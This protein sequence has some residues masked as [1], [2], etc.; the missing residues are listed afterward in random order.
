[1]RILVC[2]GR[3]YGNWAQLCKT[4]K[5]LHEVRPITSIIH[6]DAFGADAMGATWGHLNGIFVKPFPIER[7]DWKKYDKAAG[8]MRNQQMLDEGKPDLVVAFP[9]NNGTADMVRRARAVGVEVLEV[10]G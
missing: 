5:A 8:G 3:H 9:G 6:G 7:M 1:M 2:G 4:L 10:R